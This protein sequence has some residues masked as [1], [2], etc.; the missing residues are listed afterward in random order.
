M[1]QICISKV[2][3]FFFKFLL[4]KSLLALYPVYI[5]FQYNCVTLH[6]STLLNYVT[7]GFIGG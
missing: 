7:A 5:L 6:C 2:S 3:A 4:G 1:L